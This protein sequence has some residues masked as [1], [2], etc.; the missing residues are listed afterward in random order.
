MFRSGC[1]EVLHSPRGKLGVER[2]V[3]GGLFSGCRKSEL[4]IAM[5]ELMI[6]QDTVVYAG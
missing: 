1:D 3:V 4:E 2:K 6:A 5:A